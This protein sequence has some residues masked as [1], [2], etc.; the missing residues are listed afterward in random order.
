MTDPNL[1]F[2]IFAIMLAGAVPFLVFIVL[3]AHRARRDA[4]FHTS[5]TAKPQIPVS[6]YGENFEG[7]VQ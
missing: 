1:I 2:C 7:D 4:D 3:M 5:R 6:F